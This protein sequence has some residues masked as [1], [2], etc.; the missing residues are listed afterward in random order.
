[1]V[2][3]AYGCCICGENIDEDAH[4]LD[5][6]Y[7]QINTNIS[8]DEEEQLEQG[9][10]CHYECFKK[11]MDHDGHLNL[12]DQDPYVA[13][14]YLKAGK[15]KKAIDIYQK[16]LPETD[17]PETM[18][19][20]HTGM[21]QAYKQLKDYANQNEMLERGLKLCNEG[22]ESAGIYYEA[23]ALAYTSDEFHQADDYL[24]KFK[25]TFE[26]EFPDD[27]PERTENEIKYFGAVLAL[28]LAINENDNAR[29]MCSE[30][31]DAMGTYTPTSAEEGEWCNAIGASIQFLKDADLMHRLAS[32]TFIRSSSPSLEFAYKG[33]A[34]KMQG[35]NEAAHQ[36]FFEYK[37][38][39]REQI[40]YNGKD[41]D[42]LW[43][44]LKQ[45]PLEIMDFEIPDLDPP[46]SILVDQYIERY[47]KL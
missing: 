27:S 5:P 36:Q 24:E 23:A 17:D 32:S 10:F 29:S 8:G 15:Y 30:W 47:R 9:F 12:E 35:N 25:K 21:T 7:I 26:I 18:Q 40:E 39:F 41:F 2:L 46:L 31:L 44:G 37:R 45:T 3:V 22:N 34:E 6:C 28:H 38:I 43:E 19:L 11:I 4:K 14:E 16:L 33:L 1:M 20:I 42:E 13:S